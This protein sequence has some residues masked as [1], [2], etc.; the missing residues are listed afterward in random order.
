MDFVSTEMESVLNRI[1]EMNQKAV[2]YQDL[3][4]VLD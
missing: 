2:L 1:V 3:L 4:L